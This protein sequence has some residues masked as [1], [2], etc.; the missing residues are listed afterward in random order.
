[1]LSPLLSEI[2]SLTHVV[3]DPLSKRLNGLHALVIPEHTKLSHDGLMQALVN[4]QEAMT[5][6]YHVNGALPG[7][8]LLFE[9]S[10]LLQVLIDLHDQ[11]L[12]ADV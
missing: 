8:F 6:A 7:A 11:L 9:N 12:L 10:D 3:R 2:R 1:M 4:P 5:I